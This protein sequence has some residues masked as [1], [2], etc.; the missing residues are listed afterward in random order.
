MNDAG[1]VRFSVPRR[2]FYPVSVTGKGV[3]A[4]LVQYYPGK[5]VSETHIVFRVKLEPCESYW[6]TGTITDLRSGRLIPGALVRTGDANEYTQAD[7]YGRFG[8]WASRKPLDVHGR[9]GGRQN[10]RFEAYGFLGFSRNVEPAASH[11]AQSGL[12]DTA[13][14]GDETGPWRIAKRPLVELRGVVRNC[15]ATGSDRDFVRPAVEYEDDSQVM[16]ALVPLAADGSFVM[17][18]APW[19]LREVRGGVGSGSSATY[20]TAAIPLETWNGDGPY[21]AELTITGR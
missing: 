3:R 5:R 4:I 1:L 14:G 2:R 21:H 17:E 6:C 15:G 12:A 8:L 10:L 19:G 20:F 11:D 9:D 18:R 13:P 7:E 16:P